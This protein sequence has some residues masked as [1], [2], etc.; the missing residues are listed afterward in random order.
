MG[1]TILIVLLRSFKCNPFKVNDGADIY[2]IEWLTDFEFTFLQIAEGG[3]IITNPQIIAN[4]I[5]D[6]RSE[7][8]SK[9]SG[10]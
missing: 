7:N 9:F 2:K 3:P 4:T 1:Y 5:E 6:I 10:L 8:K